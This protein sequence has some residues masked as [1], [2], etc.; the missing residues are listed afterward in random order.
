MGGDTLGI[1]SRNTGYVA[2]IGMCESS[3]LPSLAGVPIST[4]APLVRRI[5]APAAV[6]TKQSASKPNLPIN[7]CPSDSVD[8]PNGVLRLRRMRT[9]LQG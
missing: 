2:A 3:G 1:G 6:D 9:S 7:I 4:G 5:F 8:V